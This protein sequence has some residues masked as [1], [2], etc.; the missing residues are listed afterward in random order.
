MKELIDARLYAEKVAAFLL[1]MQEHEFGQLKNN[2]AYKLS[3]RFEY[4]HPFESE[5]DIILA[6]LILEEDSTDN[7][8][9][10]EE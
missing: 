2:T 3:L 6:D 8:S 10:K 4:K 9:C 1:G 7:S 5:T